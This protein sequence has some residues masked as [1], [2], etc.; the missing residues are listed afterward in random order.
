MIISLCASIIAT[1]KYFDDIKNKCENSHKALLKVFECFL[2]TNI[3][4]V[5]FS[6]LE[7]MTDVI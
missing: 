3:S 5:K 1:S 7:A 4:E 6:F 2:R